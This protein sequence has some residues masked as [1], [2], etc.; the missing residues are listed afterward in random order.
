MKHYVCFLCEIVGKVRKIDIFVFSI[1]YTF[2]V[3]EVSVC[4]LTLNFGILV[5][6]FNISEHDIKFKKKP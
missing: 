3:Y 4:N 1:A 6:L 5:T 2:M